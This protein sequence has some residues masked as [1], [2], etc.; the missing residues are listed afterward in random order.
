MTEQSELPKGMRTVPTEYQ[1]YEE[2][3]KPMN[4][5]IY[6]YSSSIREAL[7]SI[8]GLN[9]KVKQMEMA[10]AFNAPALISLVIEVSEQ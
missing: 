10:E 4:H 2:E 3:K 7:E 1:D 8:E 9:L 5:S 6:N